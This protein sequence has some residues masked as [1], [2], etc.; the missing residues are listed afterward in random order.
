[1]RHVDRDAAVAVDLASVQAIIDHADAEEERARH[2][3]VGQHHHHRTFKALTVESEQT[4]RHDGHMRHRR[5]SNQLLHIRLN[6][7]DQRGI[8]HG[9]D[10]EAPHQ[11]REI[12]TGFGEEGQAETDETI[13]AH[14]E[15]HA[16]QNNRTS[17]R[18]LNVRIGKPGVH[19]PHRHLHRKRGEEGQPQQILRLHRE[20]IF[21]Q[22]GDR[23]G[24]RQVHDPQ[25]GDQHQHR[26]KQRI[27]EELVAG[28]DTIRAA[29]DADDEIHRDQACL[30]QDVEQEEILRCEDADHQRFHEQERGHIFWHA[31]L[32]RVPAGADTDRHQEDGQDDQHQ[33]DAV[34]A[35]RPAETAEQLGVFDELPLGPADLV[36]GP[37]IEA[38]RQVDQ[39][40][41]QRDGARSPGRGEQS[42]HSRN[43]W[44]RQHQRKDGKTGHCHK[45]FSLPA[46]I[47]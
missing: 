35:K 39:R 38:Q 26:A 37:E 14:L 11:R 8:N 20:V 21:H 7:R 46:F 19:R 34:N 28:V 18:R 16:C 41:H 22:H 29:P 4:Q 5:I 40:R 44:H 36:I 45:T 17:G 33:C 31:L 24:A 1:M 42:R 25:H 10:R 43:R 9:D 15:Q 30:K 47:E 12:G 23:G 3:T 6:Q 32:D 13:A 27:E 2:Q